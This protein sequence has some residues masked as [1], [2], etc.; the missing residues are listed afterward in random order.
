M[1]IHSSF[2][3]ISIVC[4]LV[5]EKYGANP[6]IAVNFDSTATKRVRLALFVAVYQY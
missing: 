2:K 6:L 5:N 4:S 1:E 3:L